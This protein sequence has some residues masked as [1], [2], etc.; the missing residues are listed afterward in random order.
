MG[1]EDRVLADIVDGEPNASDQP[2][3][4]VPEC[5]PKAIRHRIGSDGELTQ[6]RTEP[7]AADV[8]PDKDGRDNARLKILAGLLGVGFDELRQRDR[9]RHRR[10]VILAT[11]AAVAIITALAGTWLLQERAERRDV[12]RQLA[13]KYEERARALIV[14]G[15]LAGAAL[16]FAEAN[17]L[18][19]KRARRDAALQRRQ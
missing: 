10:R 8:R 2:D 7:I 15:E 13:S 5:F 4:G 12:D 1:R 16:F 19:P 14:T 17:H 6:E 3:S 18:D 9:V 11:T